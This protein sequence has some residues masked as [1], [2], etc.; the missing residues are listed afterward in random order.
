[1]KPPLNFSREIKLTEKA[2]ALAL[3]RSMSFK[4]TFKLPH[5]GVS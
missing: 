3:L 5:S 2:L 1:M 4:L